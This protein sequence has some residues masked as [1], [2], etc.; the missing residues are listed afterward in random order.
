[1][2]IKTPIQPAGLIFSRETNEM[3]MP[4]MI[5][6]LSVMGNTTAAGISFSASRV[7][8]TPT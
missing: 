6:A 4:S 5:G 7:Q 2:P 1:M 8:Y 3:N